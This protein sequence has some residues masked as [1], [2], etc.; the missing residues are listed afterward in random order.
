M[1]GARAEVAVLAYNV[2]RTHL[3]NNIV[4]LIE[5]IEE[6]PREI[7]RPAVRQITPRI[8][9]PFLNGINRKWFPGTIERQHRRPRKRRRTSVEHHALSKCCDL[10]MPAIHAVSPWRKFVGFSFHDRRKVFEQFQIF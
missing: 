7:E 4:Q 10:L 8:A 1:S 9:P 2:E 6:R 5:L 3:W